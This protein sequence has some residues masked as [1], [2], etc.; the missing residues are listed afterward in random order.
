M[1]MLSTDRYGPELAV[2][3]DLGPTWAM[4]GFGH[5]H[6]VVSNKNFSGSASK[7]IEILALHMLHLLFIL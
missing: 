6:C 5:M 1:R 7:G 3:R 4:H 2:L